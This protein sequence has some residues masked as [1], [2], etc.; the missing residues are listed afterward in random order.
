LTELLVKLTGVATTRITHLPSG[1]V[2]DSAIAR[3]YGGPGGAFSSTDLVAAA[4]GSCIATNLGPIAERHAIALDRFELRVRK[5]LSTEP[6][7]IA[8]LEVRIQVRGPVPTEL[9]ERFRAAAHA[10]TV[11]RSLHPD[12]ECVIELVYDQARI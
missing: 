2:V 9:R 11:H 5:E 1:A 7:R 4:L 12:L 6:K 3:E 8:R 10:C